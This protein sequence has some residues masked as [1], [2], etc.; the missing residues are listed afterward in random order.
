M[1][2]FTSFNPGYSP[3]ASLS[4][5]VKARFGIASIPTS[6]ITAAISACSFSLR[7]QSVEQHR[8]PL[9]KQTYPAESEEQHLRDMEDWGF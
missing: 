2:D 1:P 7:S 3:T 5:A 6:D 9:L 8:R 4:V